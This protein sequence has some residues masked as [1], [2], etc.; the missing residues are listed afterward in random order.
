M[1]VEY[2]CQQFL[3]CPVHVV[4]IFESICYVEGF[5]G[6]VVVVLNRIKVVSR[7]SPQ[8]E[9]SLGRTSVCV[10][11][12]VCGCFDCGN[13]VQARADPK[14]TPKRKKRNSTTVSPYKGKKASKF[15]KGQDAEVDGGPWRKIET[16]SNFLP[17]RVAKS[18]NFPKF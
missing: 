4:N 12:E 18:G 7:Q 13:I 1:I 16:L 2:I 17:G 15:M 11:T 9:V 3:P 10:R 5:G 14:K 6:N 8:V